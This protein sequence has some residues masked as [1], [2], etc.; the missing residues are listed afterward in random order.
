MQ[1]KHLNKSDFFGPTYGE[2]GSAG[3]AKCSTFAETFHFTAPKNEIL[4]FIQM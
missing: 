2:G 4:G 1:N 3:W